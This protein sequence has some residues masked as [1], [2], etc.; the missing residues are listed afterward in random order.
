MEGK[1][2]EGCFKGLKLNAMG[3]EFFLIHIVTRSQ[4]SL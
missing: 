2:G 3:L 1:D 4:L